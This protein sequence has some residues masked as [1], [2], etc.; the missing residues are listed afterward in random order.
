MGVSLWIS[1]GSLFSFYAPTRKIFF[2]TSATSYYKKISFS[3]QKGS[4]EAASTYTYLIF[5]LQTGFALKAVLGLPLLI[6]KGPVDLIVRIQYI[7]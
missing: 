5:P 7:V 3:S 6:S 1:A 4:D 2:N